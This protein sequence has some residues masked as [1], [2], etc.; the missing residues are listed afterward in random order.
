MAKPSSAKKKSQGSSKSGAMTKVG[1]AEHVYTR[2]EMEIMLRQAAERS[3]DEMGAVADAAGPKMVGIN[4]VEKEDLV[5]IPFIIL[6]TMFR[7]GDMGT[8]VSVSCM[9][10]DNSIVVFN[11]GSTG[12]CRQLEGLDISPKT[13]MRVSGGLRRS[14]YDYVNPETGKKTPASTYYLNPGKPREQLGTANGA[15][16]S[17]RRSTLTR[18]ADA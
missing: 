17:S 13:P 3:F 10:K 14:D 1:D 16:G 8:Y 5:G 18:G 9:L 4:V 7:T 12:V 6:A 11:D 2:E 15:G